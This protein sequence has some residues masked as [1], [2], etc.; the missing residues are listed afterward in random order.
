MS[1]TEHTGDV[2]RAV[3]S[4]LARDERW[5]L[6][7]RLAASTPFRKSPR[8]R[9][10]LIFVTERELTG[11]GSEITE[12]EIGCRVF[13][14]E[15]G[16]DPTEDSI[17]RT[18]ARQLRQKVKEYFETEGRHERWILEIPKPGYV[19]VFR[20][21]KPERPAAVAA[22]QPQPRRP[23]AVLLATACAIVAL[24]AAAWLA[25]EN[26]LLR[27]GLKPPDPP[28]LLSHLI[29]SSP[30]PTKVVLADFGF[31]LMQLTARRHFSLSEYADY[32]YAS[33]EDAHVSD[34][35]ARRMWRVVS[36]NPITGI[37]AIE[38][39]GAA[40]RAAGG[41]TDKVLLRHARNLVARDFKGAEFLI[42]VGSPA[43]NPWF[44]LYEERLT[45][46]FESGHGLPDDGFRNTA[47]QRGEQADYRGQAA[48]SYARLALLPNHLGS[49]RVLLVTG[50]SMPAVEGAGEFAGN[51]DRLA[52]LLRMLGASG[53]ARLPDFEVLLRINAIDAAP[54]DTRVIAFRKK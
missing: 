36:R 51:P 44:S 22:A 3:P 53:R 34:E 14:R 52:E 2:G 50:L 54:R 6:V 30:Q 29:W 17:V 15:A 49:G 9:E 19:P 26:Y 47:P 13:G 40:L 39:A 35:D 25:R 24:A 23:R 27:A 16:Y 46:R 33:P 11:H 31:V 42:L 21:V 1:H 18:T 48:E 5:A 4:D 38:V 43:S 32:S 12:F 8:L 28:S 20:E 7:T 10:F 45:F 41:R 37:G